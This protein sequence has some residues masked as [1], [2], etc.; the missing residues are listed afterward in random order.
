MADYKIS[1]IWKNDDVITHYAMH[2]VTKNGHTRAKKVSKKDA[3]E[4]LE[5]SGNSAVTWIWN[6]KTCVWN[7]G[8]S[9]EV[10]NAANK[11]LR[12]NPDNKETNNLGHLIDYDWISS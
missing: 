11:Y 10:V 12:S 8:E 6:Y 9:V 4:L 2:T 3:I 5:K 1:G 7:D